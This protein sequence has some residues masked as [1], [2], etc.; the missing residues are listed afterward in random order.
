M[1]LET[2]ID[3]LDITILKGGGDEVGKWALDHGFFLTPDAPEMLDFYAAAARSSWPRASTPL[4]RRDLGQQTRRRHADHAH[5][6]DRRAVGAA[7]HPRLG[8]DKSQIVDA[9]VFL[10]TDDQP[11]LLAGGR[12]LRLERSEQASASLLSDLRS[13]KGMEWVPDQMWF[14]YLRVEA[15]AGDLD[16]DLAPRRDP[17]S[18]RR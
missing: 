15:P 8:L 7:A 18:R 16:Y 9:D 17:T 3:A 13:D 1:L 6:P 4:A 2:K 10:L 11:K 14:T 5:D 12:G